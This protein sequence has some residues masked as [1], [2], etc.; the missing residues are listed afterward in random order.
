MNSRAVHLP[1]WFD[2]V[3]RCQLLLSCARLWQD[4]PFFANSCSPGPQGGVD[5][6]NLANA[7]YSTCA[8]IPRQKIPPQV[9]D[10]GQHSTYSALIAAFEQWP[11][12]RARFRRLPDCS[13]ENILPGD[14][15]LFRAGKV[16]HHCGIML[17]A[18][19]VLHAYAPGGV[20]RTQLQAV[21]RGRS[22]F[23]LLEA[24]FRPIP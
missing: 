3:E 15:L 16:P 22:L 13:P 2:T 24:V 9:M 4:T 10:A 5:C 1:T 19:E 14:A 7:V 8:V 23:G 11:D 6:V 18:G 17:I 21:I 12:L 20:R